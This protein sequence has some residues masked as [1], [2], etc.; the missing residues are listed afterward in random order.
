M[1]RKLTVNEARQRVSAKIVQVAVA[2]AAVVV[3]TIGNFTSNWI[4]PS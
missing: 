1:G 2:V 3:A 4:W